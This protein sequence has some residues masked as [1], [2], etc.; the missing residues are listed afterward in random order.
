M[1]RAKIAINDRKIVRFIIVESWPKWPS[2][3]VGLLTLSF[4][5]GY[6]NLALEFNYQLISPGL[7]HRFDPTQ[8]FV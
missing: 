7:I 1:T 6:F 5:A 3:T 4:A 8:R 2:L